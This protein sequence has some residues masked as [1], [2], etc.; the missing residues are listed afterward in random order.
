MRFLLRTRISILLS[1]T[2]KRLSGNPYYPKCESDGSLLAILSQPHSPVK[3]VKLFCDKPKKSHSH[4]FAWHSCSLQLPAITWLDHTRLVIGHSHSS[5]LKSVVFRN[6]CPWLP[7]TFP[8]DMVVLMR[9]AMATHQGLCNVWHRPCFRSLFCVDSDVQTCILTEKKMLC[10][11]FIY[12]VLNVTYSICI[13]SHPRH[14]L[15]NEHLGGN[16]G[17]L[18]KSCFVTCS[19]SV[20]WIVI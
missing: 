15:F 4:W 2:E 8:R 10:D 20:V 5:L 17:S 9:T 13:K 7:D 14:F 18:N 11:D 3:L 19:A 16:R 1:L 6:S 12:S